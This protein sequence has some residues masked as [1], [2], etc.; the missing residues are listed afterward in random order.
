MRSKWKG[1]YIDDIL[2]KFLKSKEL[3]LNEKWLIKKP[4]VRRS[5]F[6]S[7]FLEKT[8]I[9]HTG[10]SIVEKQ[11]TKKFLNLKFGQ[12][13][14]SKYTPVHKSQTKQKRRMRHERRMR[15]KHKKNLKKKRMGYVVD[16]L[17]FRLKNC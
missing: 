7:D 14:I 4:G 17:L 8:I 9:V 12:F 15:R 11:F 1:F 10:H 6:I 16:P 5:V 2:I 13:A 3:I